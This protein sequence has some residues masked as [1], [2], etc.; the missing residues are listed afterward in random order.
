MKIVSLE[1]ITRYLE[2]SYAILIDDITTEQK[3]IAD[4]NELLKGSMERLEFWQ[5]RKEEEANVP[6]LAA[7]IFTS[8]NEKNEFFAG[9]AAVEEFKAKLQ[10]F[11]ETGKYPFDIAKMA[12]I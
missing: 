4:L 3:M 12:K 9:D 10:H 7:N 8:L 5:K 11:A 6:R 1:I 2:M